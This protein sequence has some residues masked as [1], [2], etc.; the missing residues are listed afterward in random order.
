MPCII[1]SPV[2]RIAGAA[3]CRAAPP[4]DADGDRRA[5]HAAVA[6]AHLDAHA[7]ARVGAEAAAGDGD[8]A[9]E[10]QP[11]AAAPPPDGVMHSSGRM[12]PI[13]QLS[14]TRT[15]S[16]RPARDPA[17]DRD[18][19]SARC[20]TSCGRCTCRPRGAVGLR[21]RRREAPGQAIARPR[22]RVAQERRRA[23]DLVASL[24]SA[25]ARP[26]TH[27]KYVT[28]APLARKK[29][30]ADD[31]GVSRVGG[32]EVRDAGGFAGVDRSAAASRGAAALRRAGSAAS[33]AQRRSA[34]RRRGR[35]G[36]ATGGRPCDDVR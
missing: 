29:S 27:S 20:R 35:C 9:R 22:R 1:E 36:A 23:G 28:G 6:D 19:R 16:S 25:R 10:A 5:A 11:L 3:A 14:A 13:S 21:R 31:A 4:S 8:G 17:R 15:R 7:P 2:A 30:E 26:P 24:P 18:A 34:A 32:E 12:P 33:T